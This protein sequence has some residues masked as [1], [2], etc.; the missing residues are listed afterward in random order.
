MLVADS[1][2]MDGDNM[3]DQ[4]SGQVFRFHGSMIETHLPAQTALVLTPRP[5]TAGGYSNYK[6]VP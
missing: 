5:A 1:T 2:L 3:V 4:L 6:R